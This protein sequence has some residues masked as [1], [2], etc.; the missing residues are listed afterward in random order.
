MGFFLS[1]VA[2]DRNVSITVLSVLQSDDSLLECLLKDPCPGNLLF[3]T[4]L[5]SPL[6]EHLSVAQGNMEI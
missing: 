1:A 5:A 3:Y 4:W 2:G 6:L